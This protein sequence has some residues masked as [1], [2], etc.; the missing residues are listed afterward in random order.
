MHCVFGCEN[1]V[2]IPTRTA[3]K[4]NTWA[5]DLIH[6]P[7]RDEPLNISGFK[8]LYKCFQPPRIFSFIMFHSIGLISLLVYCVGVLLLVWKTDTAKSSGQRVA[9]SVI[10]IAVV[11][12]PYLYWR[13]ISAYW[14]SSNDGPVKIEASWW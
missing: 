2:K 1:A 11:L 13:D 4:D 10:F 12:V 7:I 9:A 8:P 3:P 6:L 14:H 5:P